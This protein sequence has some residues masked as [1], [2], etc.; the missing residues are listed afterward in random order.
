MTNEKNVLL[1]HFFFFFFVSTEVKVC[2]INLL[3]CQCT[4]FSEKYSSHRLSVIEWKFEIKIHL[5]TRCLAME[6]FSFLIYYSS[7]ACF[8]LPKDKHYISKNVLCLMIAICYISIWT[9]LFILSVLDNL[10]FY[11]IF[12]S[13]I[14]KAVDRW[15]YSDLHFRFF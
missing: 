13:W 5:I 2:Q 9:F 11:W 8:N 15:K 1:I 7:I 12:Q 14:Y 10:C 3:P 6:F 4:N